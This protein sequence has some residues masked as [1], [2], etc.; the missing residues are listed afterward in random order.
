MTAALTD[1]VLDEVRD[2]RGVEDEECYAATRS[3]YPNTHRHAEGGETAAKELNQL[4]DRAMRE[5]FEKYAMQLN[6]LG[7]RHNRVLPACER[8]R[9]GRKTVLRFAQH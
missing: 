5:L 7:S 2:S 4:T 6:K 9:R 3:L 1:T 8:A